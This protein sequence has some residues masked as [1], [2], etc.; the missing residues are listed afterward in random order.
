MLIERKK[1]HFDVF[2]LGEEFGKGTG[3]FSFNLIE[4]TVFG[5]HIFEYLYNSLRF[6]FLK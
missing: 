1:R 3:I 6:L 5:S 4:A 2:L